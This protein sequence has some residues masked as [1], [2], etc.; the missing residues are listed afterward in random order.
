MFKSDPKKQMMLGIAIC[1]LSLLVS[2]LEYFTG[3]RQQAVGGI[4]GMAIGAYL[5]YQGRQRLHQQRIK[6]ESKSGPKIGP[7]DF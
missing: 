1:I 4:T 2:V 5:A 6:E 7:L 3:Q